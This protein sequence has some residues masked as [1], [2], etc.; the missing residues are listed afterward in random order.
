MK[1]TTRIDA[2]LGIIYNYWQAN[3]HWI[4]AE[5]NKFLKEKDEYKDTSYFHKVEKPTIIAHLIQEGFIVKDKDEDLY[6]CTWKGCIF[7][8]SG[9]YAA[10]FRREKIT[11]IFQLV[12][13]LLVAFGALVATI[14]YLHEILKFLDVICD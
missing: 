14:Y 7:H 11:S 8:E 13:T 9:G 10:K 1:S 5:L 12:T 4:D 6:T 2:T 3:I